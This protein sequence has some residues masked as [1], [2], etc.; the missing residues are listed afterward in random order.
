MARAGAD[1]TNYPHGTMCGVFPFQIATRFGLG[2]HFS[3][4]NCP[5]NMN[6]QTNGYR[7]L[8]GNTLVVC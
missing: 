4:I 8:F 6:A 2:A 5:R 3:G 7:S 1:Q